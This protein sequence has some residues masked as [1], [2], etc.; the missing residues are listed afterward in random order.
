MKFSRAVERPEF[1]RI[2]QTL[3]LSK[4]YVFIDITLPKEIVAESFFITA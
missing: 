4:G 2:C 3:N 1:T